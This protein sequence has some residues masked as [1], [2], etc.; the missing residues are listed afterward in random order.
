M[1]VLDNQQASVADAGQ[2]SFAGDDLLVEAVAA[3]IKQDVDW[4]DGVQRLRPEVRIR[5]AA[6]QDF[7]AMVP[8]ADSVGVQVDADNARAGREKVAPHEERAAGQDPDLDKGHRAVAIRGKEA[9][10]D[11]EVGGV[12]G[13]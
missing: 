8:P 13:G 11:R 2:R 1:G 10:I 7:K 3:I 4:A 5:L 12:L 9:V 6:D